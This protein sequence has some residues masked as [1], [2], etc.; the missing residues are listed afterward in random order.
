MWLNACL[1]SSL[2]FSTNS[3]AFS[4]FFVVFP[5]MSCPGRT[6]S[7]PCVRKNGEYPNP[8]TTADL[9]ANATAGRYLCHSVTPPSISELMAPFI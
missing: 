7:L 6:G 8:F 4:G 5:T 1:S 9:Y 3:D 2:I